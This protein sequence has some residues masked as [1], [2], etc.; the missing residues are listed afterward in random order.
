[1]VLAALGLSLSRALGIVEVGVLSTVS[2]YLIDNS[3]VTLALEVLLGRF[4][5][6][7]SI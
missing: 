4:C 6:R 2:V 5:P 3:G 1:M 7:F